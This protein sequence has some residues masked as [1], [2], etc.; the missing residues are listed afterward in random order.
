MYP[1]FIRNLTAFDTITAVRLDFWLAGEVGTMSIEDMLHYRAVRE[2]ARFPALLNV[3]GDMDEADA[4]T[5]VTLGVQA[6]ILTVSDMGAKT[7][8]QVDALRELLAKVH[9]EEKDAAALGMSTPGK[10]SL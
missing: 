2:A 4:L 8:K 10:K 3:R 5:L 9:Q 7:R 1:T 6:I